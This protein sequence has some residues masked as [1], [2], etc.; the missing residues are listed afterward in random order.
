M[1]SFKQT[2]TYSLLLISLLASSTLYAAGIGNNIVVRLVGTA[3]AYPGNDLFEQHG[4]EP[5][6]ALC[7]DVDLVDAKTGNAIGTASDCL[8][9]I[10]SSVTDDGVG[11]LTDSETFNR[12]FDRAHCSD[13]LPATPI[14][15]SQSEK[16]NGILPRARR[17]GSAS[18]PAPETSRPLPSRMLNS[19]LPQE[20]CLKNFGS[21]APTAV[22]RTSSVKNF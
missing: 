21:E 20:S 15:N 17:K 14:A 5:L 10:T 11:L 18:T 3:T 22:A 4:L 6:D 8:S 9:S 19:S 1:K 7:F 13:V 16:M 2:A 12:K